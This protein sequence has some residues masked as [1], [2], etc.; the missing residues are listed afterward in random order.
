MISSILVPLDGSPLAELALPWAFDLAQKYDARVVLL[1]V[2]ILPDVWS[3]QDAP[4]MDSRLDELETQ[5]MKYLL[6]VESRHKHTKVP[7][8]AEYAVGNATQRIV[9]RSNQPDCSMVV[10]NSHGRDGL[11]R[12]MIGSVAEKVARHAGCPVLLIRKPEANQK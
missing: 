1:R 2:G 10:M 8:Q 7:V 6:E 11:T 12:W 3:L 5:C 9:E 4:E